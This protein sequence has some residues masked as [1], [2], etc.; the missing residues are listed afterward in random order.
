MFDFI[1]PV[2]KPAF[3]DAKHTLFIV[4]GRTLLSSVSAQPGSSRA[5]TNESL[6]LVHARTLFVVPEPG[7]CN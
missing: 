2:D 5:G 7:P 4:S 1:W 6:A 3:V